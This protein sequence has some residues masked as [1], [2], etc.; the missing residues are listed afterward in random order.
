MSTRPTKQEL[1]DQLQTIILQTISLIDRFEKREMQE[2]MP[3][4]YAQLYEVLE[5]S[6][7]QQREL[8]KQLIDS[9]IG[10]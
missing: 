6:I 7:K 2:V 10:G 1:I 4:D 5:K 3:V 9:E 8:Q